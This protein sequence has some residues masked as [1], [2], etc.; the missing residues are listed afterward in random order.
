MYSAKSRSPVRGGG[1]TESQDFAATQSAIKPRVQA[2]QANI[3]EF[4]K[5]LNENKK[6]S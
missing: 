2:V 1:V 3:V 5:D 4:N 6:E